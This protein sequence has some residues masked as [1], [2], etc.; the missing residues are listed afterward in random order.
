MNV[1]D[2]SVRGEIYSV[3]GRLA[4]RLV[5]AASAGHRFD[6]AYRAA[7]V[8]AARHHVDDI[9]NCCFPRSLVDEA[10]AHAP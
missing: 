9:E 3:G 6:L 2:C 10:A 8:T 7:D 5:T 4:R 1:P